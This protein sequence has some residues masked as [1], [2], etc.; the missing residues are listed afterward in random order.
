MSES[1]G[2]AKQV[3]RLINRGLL[4]QLSC[5]AVAGSSISAV[6]FGLGGLAISLAFFLASVVLA[7]LF[8]ENERRVALFYSFFF[9]VLAGLFSFAF[10]GFIDLLLAFPTSI[11]LVVFFFFVLRFF[12]LSDRVDAIVLDC[13]KGF[14]RVEVSWHLSSGVKPG[15]YLVKCEKR[16]SGMV[17]VLVEKGFFSDKPLSVL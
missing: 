16:R 9:L 2:K 5:L 13:F 1:K 17:R 8:E 14:A 10:L 7:F 6:F 3:L 12:L 11:A 15:I 4:F